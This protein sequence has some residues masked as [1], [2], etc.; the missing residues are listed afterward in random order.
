MN[1]LFTNQNSYQNIIFTN[2]YGQPYIYYL[3][4]S[5]YS[6]SKYQSQAFLTENISGDTGQINQIDN[7]RFDSPNF[8]SI[9]ETP[10]TLAIFS[11]DE[12]LRQG[13]DQ[14]P[15]FSEFIP[16]SPINNISTFYAYQTN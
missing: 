6:P 16:L 15:D 5:K 7:I 10:N 8:N 3:F 2:F 14:T 13:I 1:Y 11:Y 4:Y 12:I 9:K